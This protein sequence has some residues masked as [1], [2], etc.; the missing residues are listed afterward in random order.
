MGVVVL[1]SGGH[2]SANL[3]KR[4]APDCIA[5]FV[6]YGQEARLRE[7]RAVLNICSYFD[8]EVRIDRIDPLPIV[9]GTGDVVA[10]R[11][12]RLIAQAIPIAVGAGAS[13]IQ[14]GTT[15]LD[16][17]AFPDCRP[18]FIETISAATQSAY[19]VRVTA[20]LKTRPSYAVAGTWSCYRGDAKP[21]G[22]C[23][24]CRQ[25]YQA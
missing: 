9:D 5:L 25:G 4:A 20:P 16:F 12:L 13:E 1:F 22:V 11:N 15:D 18:G 23:R 24:S 6:D 3:V 10:G 14:I 17:E 2:D 7:L 19:G 8:V 21:C